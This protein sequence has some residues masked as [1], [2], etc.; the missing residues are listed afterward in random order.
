MN[1]TN[2][3]SRYGRTPARRLTQRI[4]LIVGSALGAMLVVAWAAWTGLLAAGP[5]L[6]QETIAYEVVSDE[7]VTVQFSIS[8]DPGHEVICALAAQ[9]ERHAVVGWRV[10]TIPASQDYLRSFEEALVTTEPAVVGL[11]RECRLT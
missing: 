7:M 1:T 4:L 3:D 10:L 11:I 9:S 2:L 6:D 5:N 8:V